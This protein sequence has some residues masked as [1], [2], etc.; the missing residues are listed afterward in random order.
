MLVPGMARMLSAKKEATMNGW[1]PSLDWFPISFAA[2]VWIL[3][4]GTIGYAA[5]L[6]TFRGPHRR[7]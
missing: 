2:I 1:I 5:I 6:A 3:V 4:I 7:A